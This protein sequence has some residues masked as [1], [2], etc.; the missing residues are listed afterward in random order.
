MSL[1]LAVA[2][3]VARGPRLGGKVKVMV[4][5]SCLH[6]ARSSDIPCCSAVP[7]AMA[8]DLISLEDA[9]EAVA[10]EE[11]DN[12]VNVPEI[13]VHPSEPVSAWAEQ[14]TTSVGCTAVKARM[15]RGAR[16]RST[17]FAGRSGRV[18]F[19]NQAKQRRRLGAR[20]RAVGTKY[21][22]PPVAPVAF[23]SSRLR[24]PIQSLGCR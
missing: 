6:A 14:T 16:F 17:R 20:L 23:D 3:L 9:N 8:A 11:K 19:A 18:P 24:F 4:Q 1:A 5:P 2:I 10:D 22:M 21:E 12:L 13:H 15:V 7:V